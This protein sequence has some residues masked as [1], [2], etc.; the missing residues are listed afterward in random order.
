M[1]FHRI[2]KRGIRKPVQNSRSLVN[3]GCRCGVSASSTMAIGSSTSGNSSFSC[4]THCL[5]KMTMMQNATNITT[6]IR[7]SHQ[8]RGTTHTAHGIDS[9]GGRP[10][11][12]HCIACPWRL[13]TTQS[14]M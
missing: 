1:A 11:K 9:P 8:N 5:R 13:G 4:S 2:T 10:S 12:N 3:R 7:L 6:I 14:G